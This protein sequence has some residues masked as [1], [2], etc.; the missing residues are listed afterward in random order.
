MESELAALRGRVEALESWQAEAMSNKAHLPP[1]PPH[2]DGEIRKVL[3]LISEYN[4]SR[5]ISCKD[6]EYTDYPWHY[7]RAYDWEQKGKGLCVAAER[8]IKLGCGTYAPHEDPPE[9]NF[10]MIQ[11]FNTHKTGVQGHGWSA[12]ARPVFAVDFSAAKFRELQE[13]LAR[14]PEA[15]VRLI[16]REPKGEVDPNAQWFTESHWYVEDSKITGVRVV[17]KM[18]QDPRPVERLV[19]FTFQADEFDAGDE[20]EVETLVAAVVPV[21]LATDTTIRLPTPT[22]AGERLVHVPV[23]PPDPASL[24]CEWGGDSECPALVSCTC[25]GPAVATPTSTLDKSGN[26]VCFISTP[27]VKINNDAQSRVEVSSFSME[28]K[29]VHHRLDPEQTAEALGVASGGWAEVEGGCEY[30]GCH[31]GSRNA[32]WKPTSRSFHIPAESTE[33]KAFRGRLQKPAEEAARNHWGGYNDNELCNRR[34]HHAFLP[35]EVS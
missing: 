20:P 7:L 29:L 23:E 9:G 33:F 8:S 24:L 30:G 13:L 18:S 19:R 25:E 16:H 27:A 15:A 2:S 31:E 17:T 1:V 12:K 4:A 3:Q 26:L 6:R 11:H 35:D 22:F 32:N 5:W 21:Q 34:V 28:Y 14:Q 10:L